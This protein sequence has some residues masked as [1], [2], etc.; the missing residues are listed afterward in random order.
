MINVGLHHIVPT[1]FALE[2]LFLYP[3][4]F[5]ISGITLGIYCSGKFSKVNPNSYDAEYYFI[6][7]VYLFSL[8]IGTFLGIGLKKLFNNSAW[9]LFLILTEKTGISRPTA[10]VHL[11]A[12]IF[13]KLI[14]DS[15]YRAVLKGYINI[16]SEN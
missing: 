4:L 16:F 6:N 8:I 13:L 10:A 3:S 9:V 15:K 1:S 14:L 12:R 2:G 11:L 7:S 5:I